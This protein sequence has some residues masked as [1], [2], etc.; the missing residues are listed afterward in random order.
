MFFGS[1]QESTVWKP[2]CFREWKGRESQN[3]TD[4]PVEKVHHLSLDVYPKT[5]REWNEM[6]HVPYAG[7][8]ESLEYIIMCTCLKMLFRW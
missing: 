4:T 3:T 8:I 1:F 2:K 5:E 6:D 7:V